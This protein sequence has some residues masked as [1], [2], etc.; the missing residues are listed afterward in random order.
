MAEQEALTREYL[1][2]LLV[3]RLDDYVVL[4]L[5]P[6]G[7]IKSWHPGVE[8]QL[9]YRAEEFVGKSGEILLPLADRLKGG[10]RRELQTAI[11]TGRASDT[12]WAITKSGRPIFVEGIA[13]SLR[14]PAT[15]ELVG[16]GKVLRDVTERKQTEEDRKALTQ[17]LDES[18]VFIRDWDGVIEHWT[19]GCARLYGWTRHEAIGQ[20][21][22]DL[23]QTVYSDPISNVRAKLMSD[24]AW[25]GELKQ[26][27]KDGSPVYVS[28]H[29]ILL[30]DNESE[31]P[32]VISTHT[33]I[34][35]RLEM[36]R[37]LEAAN[38][39]LKSMALELERSNADLEEF[40]RIASHDLHAPITSTRWLV[41][42]LTTR[43]GHAL[44]ADGQNY[45]KQISVGLERMTDLVEAILA[46]ARVG[47]DRIGATT[48]VNAD[49]A[50]DIAIA[51]LQ[52]DLNTS[53][54]NLVREPL[55]KVLIEAQPLAQLF[56]N[57]LSNAIKYRR[58]D[59]PLVIRIS[60]TRQENLWL[61]S[62]K[63][64]GIGVERDWFER[65]FLPLQRRHGAD[66]AGSG[67]GLATCRKIVSRAGGKIWVE[68][69]VGCG[70]NFL[71]T[72]PGPLS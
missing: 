7:S 70:S 72:L 14:H 30:S 50:L 28:A 41:D 57:L 18:V 12:N 48:A 31:A 1:F 71:F 66:I 45:L 5:D 53:G 61:L 2:D 9:G 16:F 38:E 13:L 11:E 44:N 43:H 68:S 60:S 22:D 35:S 54:A 6:N 27:R 24:G 55:P 19:K 33:D 64:N 51:N 47:K 20:V 52:G 40:A 58:K 46:H 8:K 3:S 67:I 21:A 15:G 34:T 42:L 29:W 4:L 26:K 17:A 36:Q 63:D 10:F 23:L 62:V 32:N 65:I 56:Q 25:Q 69:E 49:V 37:E 39:R 59:V